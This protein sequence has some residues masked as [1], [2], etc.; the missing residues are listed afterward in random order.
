MKVPPH[1]VVVNIEIS[2]DAFRRVV[3]LGKLVVEG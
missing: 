2:L 1:C 3:K